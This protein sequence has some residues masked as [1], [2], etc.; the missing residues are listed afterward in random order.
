M[1]VNWCDM[2][3]RFVATYL[4]MYAIIYF[5]AMVQYH[6]GL[7][8]MFLVSWIFGTTIPTCFNILMMYTAGHADSYMLSVTILIITFS[9]FSFSPICK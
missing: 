3:Y 9:A 8:N 2:L 1:W 5:L 6:A 4:Q 7:A